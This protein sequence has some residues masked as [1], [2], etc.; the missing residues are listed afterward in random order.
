MIMWVSGVFHFGNKK[1]NFF[2]C[3]FVFFLNKSAAVSCVFAVTQLEG[4][5]VVR[6]Q[7]TLEEFSLGN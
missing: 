6:A 1:S 2:V 7:E 4:N 3:F 5:D